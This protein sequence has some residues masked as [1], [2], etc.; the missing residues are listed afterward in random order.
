MAV[1]YRIDI[2]YTSEQ[3]LDVYWPTSGSAW[4]VVVILHGGDT[5]KGS[6]KGLAMR[7][8][9]H[10]AV[11]FV[12]EYQ[13]HEPPP[14]R[15]TRGAEEATCAVRFAGAHGQEYGGDPNHIV[16][17][18]HSGGAAFGSLV[19]LAGDQFPG[20][21]TVAEGDANPNVLI[22]LD[23]AYD[24]MRYI[25]DETLG[26][27]PAKEW[28]KISPYEY[29]D[30]APRRADL[31]FHLFVGLETE[32]LQDAQA[33][34]EALHRAGYPVALA[35]FPGIDHMRM[36]SENHANTVWAIVTHM[37]P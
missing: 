25:S 36:A 35:Q 9:G 31:S 13:S 23:G 37:R 18:G 33:F 8:A 27:A 1:D 21:C 20:D 2:P 17:V 14:D 34:R 24:L 28:L 22:G 32:L 10:G 12:P 30:R 6:A 5:S 15:I 4:P 26:A 7:V 19:A 11:V 29:V 3:E 16:V